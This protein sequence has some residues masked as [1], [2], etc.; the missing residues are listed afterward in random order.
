MSN[1]DIQKNKLLF[2]KYKVDKV[3]GKGSFGWVFRGKN[4]IDNSEVAIK[5]EKRNATAHLLEFESNFFLIFK[6]YGIPEIKSYGRSG[7]YYVLV[8]ELLG[9]NLC[10]IKIS[11]RNY[12]LKDI[13]MMAIQ[14]IDRIEYVHSKNIIHR[15]IKPENFLNGYKNKSTIYI[16]DFGISRKYRSSRTGK[17]VKF[18]LTGKMFGT[19]RYVSYNG[20]RGVEQSR[21]DD[22]ESIGYMLIYLIKG[23][24]PWQGMK[25]KSQD[26]QR[27]YFEMLYLKKFKT[28]EEL[29]KGLPKEFA[30]YIR[31]CKNLAFEQDPDYEYLRNLFRR[32]LLTS[33]QINDMKFSWLKVHGKNNL[34]FH[35]NDEKYINLLKRKQSPQTRLFK[36]IQNNLE[37]NENSL[38][39]KSVAKSEFSIGQNNDLPYRNRNIYKRM[40]SDDNIQRYKI[41][42]MDNANLSKDDITYNSLLAQYNMNVIKFQ[43]ENKIYELFYKRKNGKMPNFSNNQINVIKNDK[44]QVDCKSTDFNNKNASKETFDEI[45]RRQNLIKHKY[46]LS[47]DLDKID[48]INNLLSDIKNKASKSQQ[49]QKRL[50]KQIK[51]FSNDNHKE[52]GN[53]NQDKIYMNTLN[54]IENKNNLLEK[55]NNKKQNSKNYIEIKRNI[56][57][58]S[59]SNKI[60]QN[61]LNKFNSYEN[62]FSFKNIN[63]YENEK[64]RKISLENNNNLKIYKNNILNNKILKVDNAIKRTQ[65]NNNFR[66]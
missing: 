58:K 36:I 38:K 6:G 60:N 64:E 55:N 21:R 31:Y 46:S 15:D 48:I 18:S 34:E 44:N 61:L 63:V 53:L 37:K 52:E 59:S 24:L 5:I 10:E 1:Y 43:D 14:I 22:L 49:V 32:I 57:Q 28:P 7:N 66:K 3:L 45:N 65:I 33:N 26:S 62:S 9:K 40:I 19:V 16:I 25:L 42:E 56:N 27:K 50:T 17:H 4:I 12:T 13:A 29:C 20:S 35:V 11:I 2:N 51:L 47:F 54:K 41:N 23:K 8:E 30:D 39:N